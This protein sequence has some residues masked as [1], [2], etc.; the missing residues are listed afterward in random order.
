MDL[1]TW[2]SNERGRTARLAEKMGI[3]AGYLSQMAK[4]DRPIPIESW[5]LIER[6][7]AGDVTRRDLWP[8]SY[9]LIWPNLARNR[10]ARAEAGQGV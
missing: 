2:L 7:T 8:E 6:E 3:G 1:K 4:G 5:Q 10:G 9:H